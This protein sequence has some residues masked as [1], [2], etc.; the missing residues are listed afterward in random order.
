LGCRKNHLEPNDDADCRRTAGNHF[1]VVKSIYFDKPPLSNWFVS[2]HQDLT[3]SVE[4]KSDVTGF[5]HWSEKQGQIAVQPPLNVLESIYTFRIHQDDCDETNGALR[6]ISGTHLQ[7]IIRPETLSYPLAGSLCDV[8]TGGVMI[9]I[10]CLS[11]SSF[12]M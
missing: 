10:S 11:V 4:K 3:I 2:W 6:V 8:Q 1:F 5:V 9:S 12:V 7:G